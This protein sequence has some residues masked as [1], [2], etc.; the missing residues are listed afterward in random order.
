MSSYLIASRKLPSVR[1]VCHRLA[2][3]LVALDGATHIEHDLAR[4]LRDEAQVPT[5]A[6]L[7]LIETAAIEL[8]SAGHITRVTRILREGRRGAGRTT[9][10]E[11]GS[12]KS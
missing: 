8:G 10:P 1:A 9:R 4:A 12:A 6:A 11:H 2:D 3:E 5:N 7:D